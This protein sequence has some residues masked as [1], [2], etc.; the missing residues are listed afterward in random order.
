[1]MDE[2]P[3]IARRNL[4]ACSAGINRSSDPQRIFERNVA[5]DLRR[6]HHRDG[7]RG[8]SE[9]AA[10]PLHGPVCSMALWL[11]AS[12]ALYWRS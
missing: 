7:D 8:D 1:M 6:D 11:S 3:G 12:F 5:L 4:S 9:G 10:D 2:A